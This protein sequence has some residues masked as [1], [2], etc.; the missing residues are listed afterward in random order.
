MKIL[1]WYQNENALW[2]LAFFTKGMFIVSVF[3][4]VWVENI[5]SGV[6]GLMK[7]NG[8]CCFVTFHW[9]IFI[10]IDETGFFCKKCLKF[11]PLNW[12]SLN[13]CSLSVAYVFHGFWT[14][15]KHFVIWIG[16]SNVLAKLKL[17]SRRFIVIQCYKTNP[18]IKLSKHLPS[19][20]TLISVTT[21]KPSHHQKLS[22]FIK[23]S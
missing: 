22:W 1:L 10:T 13:R 8:T 4:N 18:E 19:H 3:P 2:H 6:S 7:N 11:F 17:L 5:M 23:K 20:S 16:V 12:E 9:L 15:R 21:S 14:Y